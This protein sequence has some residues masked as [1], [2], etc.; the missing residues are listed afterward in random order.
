MSGSACSHPSNLD[1]TSGIAPDLELQFDAR[2]ISPSTH[3]SS[4]LR[5]DK[6]TGFLPAVGG[7]LV[8]LARHDFISD[9]LRAG[10]CFFESGIKNSRRGELRKEQGKLSDTPVTHLIICRRLYVRKSFPF[11]GRLAFTEYT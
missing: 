1:F 11:G 9:I 3:R 10:S 2:W 7:A 8:G 4:S 6:A 5:A